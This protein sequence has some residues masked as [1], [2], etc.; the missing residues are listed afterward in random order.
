MWMKEYVSCASQEIYPAI[1]PEGFR[2]MTFV[3][4]TLTS[5]LSNNHS[6]AIDLHVAGCRHFRTGR[7]E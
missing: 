1:L 3:Q 6:V 2:G 4:G 5:C 7:S